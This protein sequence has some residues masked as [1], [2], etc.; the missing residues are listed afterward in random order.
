[1]PPTLQKPILRQ[2]GLVD[3]QVTLD[4]MIEFTS[5]RGPETADEIWCLEHPAVYTLGLNAD[6]GHVLSPGDIPV[7]QVDR[8]GQVTYHG[9]GQLV[10]YTL[11][12]LKRGRLGIRDIVC[13]LENAV[14]H[15]LAGY[16]IEARGSRDAPGVYVDGKKVASIG[17]RVRRGCSYHG[18]AVNVSNDLKPFSHINPCGYDNLEVTSLKN[19]GAPIEPELVSNDIVAALSDSLAE[20]A[21]PSTG[22]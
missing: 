13:A 1:M 19:L 8:G 3:Y 10:F 5:T 20:F 14:I 6:P 12:D 16:A 17:L 21:R 18:L 15:A 11:L 4:S 2:L 22:A 7:I 9:P